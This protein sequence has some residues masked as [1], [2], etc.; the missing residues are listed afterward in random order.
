MLI[1]FLTA[2]LGAVP[3][4]SGQELIGFHPDRAAEQL[5]REKVLAAA[6][7]PGELREWS[8]TMTPRPHHAGSPQAEANAKFMRDQFESWGYDAKIE[9]YYV[10][11]PTPKLRKLTL[12]EP[13]RYEARLQESVIEGDSTSKIAIETGL[14]PYNAYSADGDVTAELVYV[15]RGVPADYEELERRGISVKGKIVIARYGGSWRGIKPKVAYEK[16]AIGCLIFNDPGDD[17]FAVGLTYPDGPFKHEWGVQRGSVLDLP[18]RPGDPLTPMRGATRDAE[19][20]ERDQ[21]D[22]V[23]KIPVLPIAWKDA[24]PLLEA[25]EGP[26]APRSWRGALPITYRIGPGPAKV[27]L[28]LE[29]NW[30][31]TPAHNVIAKLE[32]SEYPDQWIMRGNHHD[33]W[34]IG[35]SDPISGII[36]M[37]A[38]AKAIGE[39]AKTGWRPKRTIL[40]GAWDA[41]EPALLGSTE[42]AEDHQQELREKLAIYINTDGNQRGFFSGGGSH[43][44]ETL[45]NQVTNQMTDPQTGVSVAQRRKAATRA[46][47][48]SPEAKRLASG[49][50]LRLSALGSGSDYSPF[51]QHLGIA[52]LNIGYFGEGSGGEYHTAFDSFDHY[53]THKDPGFR[54]CALLG[55]TG[56][57]L[58][59][60]LAEADVLPFDFNRT[61]ETL[62]RYVDDVMDLANQERSRIEA[63]N[64]AVKDGVFQLAADP[65]KTF[66]APEEEPLPPHLNFAPLLDARDR[67]SRAAKAAQ[68]DI[69]KATSGQASLSASQHSTLDKLIYTSERRFIAG[70]GLPRR[71]W[72]RNLMYAPGYYTGYAVKTLPGIREGVEEGMWQEAQEQIGVAAEAMMSLALL[73]EEIEALVP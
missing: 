4:A 58:T 13:T 30:D 44:L 20:L 28:Q 43:A 6:I 41:E 40:Y 25:M 55:E 3:A 73:L 8:R 53:S 71:P 51:L 59:T 49:G 7:E 42:W 27:R 21:A 46:S 14:P 47:G 38:E 19:R 57:R 5:E 63:H 66:L 60:R 11:L 50:A 10:L 61:A 9:T 39:L 33:A 32:G 62:S 36:S 67:L 35:A 56:A 45:V 31:L 2:A 24:Q 48:P 15:N 37:M 64:Q 52:S 34:V 70:E 12:L 23:M 29:F 18:K 68:A 54:Y 1:L 17:G 16:G 69:Q 65:N 72:F 26:V 22:N